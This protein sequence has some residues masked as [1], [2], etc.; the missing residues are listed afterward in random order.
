MTY[1]CR[2]TSLALVTIALATSGGARAQERSQDPTSR[3]AVTARPVP[4]AHPPLPGQPAH[5][6]LIPDL[7]ATRRPAGRGQDDLAMRFAKGAALIAGGDAAAGLPLVTNAELAKTPLADYAQYYAGVAQFELSRLADAD[8][9]LTRLVARDLQGY[10]KELAVARL[11]EVALARRDAGRAEDLLEDL[12]E[13][14]V[15]FPQEVF[16]RLGRAEEAVGHRDHALAAYRRVYY[17]FPLSAQANDAQ[18]GLERLN[19]PALAAPDRYARELARAELLFGARR[20]AQARAGFAPLA[21][22]AR[23]ADKQLISL[24]LAE[25]D[26]YLDRHRASRDALR[27]HLDGGPREAEARFFH[28]SATLAL[29]DR[30]A[31]VSL[32]RKLVADH[33]QS[34]WA[35][36]TLNNLASH[37]IRIDEDDQADAVFRELLRRFPRHRHSERAAWRVGW[38]AYRD[39][40]VAETA[41][42]FER[43]AAVFPRANNRPGWLY[44]S[45]RA[46]DQLKDPD[47][48]NARYRLTVTDYQN[49]YYGRLASAILAERKEPAVERVAAAAV[50]TPAPTSA[51][52][53][54]PTDA[55]IRALVAA[56]LYGDALAEVQHA[57][58]MWGDSPQLQ[59]TVAWIR[60]RQGLGLKSTDRFNALRGA[61]NTMRAAYPQFMAA[62]G[63]D[64]PP[65]VLRIIFPL[66]YWSL[67]TKYSAAHK[68]DPYLMAALMAQESTFTPEIRSS[69]NAYGLMQVVPAT[70]R[71]VAR[72]LGI[73][74]FSTAMLTQPETNVRLG[75]KYFKEMV[76]QFGGEFYALAGY[77]AGPHRVKRWLEEAPG[78]AQDEFVD[79]IPFPETQTYVK[80]ILG[81]AED[82]RRLYGPGGVLDPNAHLV[83]EIPS[84]S[85]RTPR[86]R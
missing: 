31:Y 45:G 37:Y 24:R 67:I 2:A 44:W 65:D 86:R 25:C 35:A 40:N 83:A 53:P 39:G 66:D 28:L 70:G 8:A 82:Y 12:S 41:E 15:S 6:W 72:R 81:T 7:A 80:R 4:T 29:G 21:G 10:L 79:N 48:A 49:S 60:H 55:V 34:E 69:A 74:R 30:A 9:T 16:L 32:A 20:Y 14:K 47:A 73:R 78:L 68:L 57:Q 43:S 77:N 54:V 33:P 58:R 51:P 62:G 59:A 56:P 3:S 71:L 13:E 26:Y 75:M 11:A 38:W 46:R 76:D 22:L 36:E 85:P 42:I 52:I 17:D 1:S 84:A 19:G 18:A 64:L 50:A 23:G 5:Y 27:P 63:E 61:I